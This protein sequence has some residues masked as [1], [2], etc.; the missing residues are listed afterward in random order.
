MTTSPRPM[1]RPDLDDARTAATL[2]Q[3]HLQTIDDDGD[4][5]EGSVQEVLVV[6]AIAVVAA[7]RELSA[8]LAAT[9]AASNRARSRGHGRA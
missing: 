3:E 4:L 1:Q 6:A 8:E 5:A 9:R 7:L 2:T